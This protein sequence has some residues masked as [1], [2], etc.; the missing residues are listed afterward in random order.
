[1][2]SKFISNSGSDY[3]KTFQRRRT[4]MADQDLTDEQLKQ[5]LADAE[6]RLR[7]K[8]TQQTQVSSQ[9]ALQVRFVPPQKNLP[10]F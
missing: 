2:I 7:I 3:C 6:Q 1:M 9:A 10:K 8:R 4:K 5:L